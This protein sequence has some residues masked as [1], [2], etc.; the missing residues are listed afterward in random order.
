MAYI[1]IENG[2]LQGQKYELGEML[3][4]G[5][6]STCDVVLR[7]PGVSRKH[8]HLVHA[9]GRYYI[10]DLE[11]RNGTYINGQPVRKNELNDKDLIN[12]SSYIIRFVSPVQ[13]TR[14]KESVVFDDDAASR[15]YDKSMS[16]DAVED[17]TGGSK[18][19]AA[20]KAEFKSLDDAITTVTALRKRLDNLYQV[21]HAL[22]STTDE[23]LLFNQ[24][25]DCLLTVFPQADRALLI[26]GN[27]IDSIEVRVVKHRRPDAGKK[28]SVR[29]SRSVIL[30]V[31]TRKQAL[32]IG[33]M[34]QDE[35]FGAAVSI[36]AQ[37]ISSIMCAP[38]I[39][40]GEHYGILQI[41]NTNLMNPFT[42]KD[43]NDLVGVSKQAAL[44]LRNAKL[45]RDFLAEANRT[46]QLQRF[47][48]PAVAKEVMNN[49]LKLGGEMRKGCTMFSDIVGFTTRSEK[50]SAEE[51]IKQLNQYYG[52]MNGIILGEKGTID[53]FGGDAIMAVW[54][55]PVAVENDASHAISCTLQMQ[56]AIV[57]FNQELVAQGSDPIAMGIGLHAGEFVAGNIGSKDRMEYTVIG[58]DVNIAAR[59]ETKT[60]GGMVMGSQALVDKIG[61]NNVFGLRFNPISLKGKAQTFPLTSIRGIRTEEGFLLSI[62]AHINTL[63]GKI[64]FYAPDTRK[65]K[66]V[67]G[68]DLPMGSGAMKLDL[69]EFLDDETYPIVLTSQSEGIFYDFIFDRT[70]SVIAKMLEQGVVETGMEISWKR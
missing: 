12:L 57:R 49:K 7:A 15:K 19:A 65:F 21:T 56:N 59:V 33:D 69:P 58:D 14:R 68:H 26:L 9:N 54:G 48:S 25:L 11:S 18:G 64:T 1:V 2:A 20:T 61:G 38:L 29:V 3:T 43:L 35:Q 28:Q 44:F 17:L 53:K 66:F 13:E 51:V 67:G 55:A 70:P 31:L 60:L 30:D 52:V 46:A 27:D 39:S 4:L 41:E 45:G 47:F 50:L 23:E 37:N 62:P 6:H 36:I 8:C 22:S 40:Q 34:S 63:S 5:R 16:M 10:E 24:V 32:L 42:T